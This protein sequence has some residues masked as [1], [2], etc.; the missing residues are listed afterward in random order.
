MIS[1]I[2]IVIVGG[3]TS[4]YM[5][6]A[7]LTG[8]VSPS[9][10]Q[11]RLIESAEIGTVGVGEATL[12][13]IKEF[14]DSLGIDEADFMRKTQASF[15]LG[16]EFRDWGKL[17]NNYIHPF[18]DFGQPIAGVEF[19]HFWT[20][21]KR[22]GISR[23]LEVYSYAIAAARNMRFDFPSEDRDSIKSTFSYAYHF[24]AS[25]YAA[26][27]REFAQ[28]RGLSR[29]EGKVIGVALKPE[30]G[31]IA[32]LTLQSGEIVQGDLFIDCSGFRGLL[33]E[34]Q[35]HAGWES[36][37]HWL[38][39]DRAYAV[40][41]ER[42][43]DFMPCTRSSS[44]EAGWQWRVPL[45]HRTG[46]GYVYSSGFINDQAASDRLMGNLDATAMAEPR[47]VRFQAGRRK[48]S[49]F[50]NCIGL[51]LASGFLEPLE[52]TSIYLVQIAV[53]NLIQLF[54]TRSMDSRLAK[55][56]NRLIDV[57][58]ERIRDFLILHYHANQRDEALWEYTRNMS[59]PDSLTYKID[60]FRHRG[61]ILRHKDGLFNP[62]SWLAVLTGQDII[63]QG[64]DRLAD[65]LDESAIHAK[66]DELSA[67]I[68]A[69]VS[70]MP[71]HDELVRDYCFL[72]ASRK[73]ESIMLGATQ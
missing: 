68:A 24:D 72:A 63:P 5:A 20:K 61:Q 70:E 3:G 40:P 41:T 55:E 49:W 2:K 53:A 56:F 67:R 47:Q 44:L 71:R 33:I 64:Y 66:M 4:G 65:N 54:P 59:V 28:D 6:A 51:G 22:L 46:N 48:H 19:R 35:L 7:A 18:G 29:T 58:Y 10:A 8:L 13:H 73:A 52:S 57:E 17:G 9:L 42:S 60:Q 25:L 37:A 50:K 62:A 31:H 15:K 21:S 45:Q 34:E 12:P 36:W 43:D 16:I 32:S 23:P 39:C 26:F 30:N 11:V 27:L 14:N 38:P 1:P 69:N